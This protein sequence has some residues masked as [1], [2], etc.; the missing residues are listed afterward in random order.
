M[1]RV[2]PRE[3]LLYNIFAK[4]LPTDVIPFEPAPRGTLSHRSRQS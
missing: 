2:P 1:P 4:D 3:L